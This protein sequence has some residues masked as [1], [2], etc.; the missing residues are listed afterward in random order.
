MCPK[1]EIFVRRRFRAESEKGEKNDGCHQERP[2]IGQAKLDNF[3]G[4]GAKK[5][6]KKVYKKMTAR[7]EDRARCRNNY[8]TNKYN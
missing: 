5:I 4:A 6:Q 2:R 8:T 1:A 7:K 3:Q